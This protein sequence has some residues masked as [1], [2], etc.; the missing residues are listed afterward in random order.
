MDKEKNPQI[1]QISQIILF[2][3][4]TLCF[5]CAALCSKIFLQKRTALSLATLF[6]LLL[7]GCSGEEAPLP[8]LAPLMVLPSPT[9]TSLPATLDISTRLPESGVV[10][11]GGGGSTTAQA[12]PKP[13]VTPT[14]VNPLINISDPNPNQ[15]LTLGSEVEV[16]G[17]VQ[18]EAEQQILVSLVSSN[19]RLLTEIAVLPNEFG[20]QTAFVLPPYVSG[21]ATMRASLL[22]ADGA[23]LSSYEVPVWLTLNKAT[24]TRYLEMFRP[25]INEKAVGGFNIFFDGEVLLPVNRTITV[26]IWADDCQTRV[27]RQSFVLGASNQPVYWQGFVVVPQDLVGP[28]C[29]VASTG[30]PGTENWREASVPINVLA[31][32]ELEARGVTI[33]N[34]PPDSEVFAGQELFLYG[35]AYNVSEGTGSISILME[36]G[37]VVTQS[38]FTTDYWGYWET[39]VTLPIDIEGLAEITVSAGE[40]DTFNESTTIIRVNPAPTPTPGP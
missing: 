15:L 5:L 14:P 23:V 12:T 38:S 17:L 34:P 4:E 19:G 3:C 10:P 25:T 37:R 13:T 16:R 29:A 30:D 40:G 7:I 6:L 20:W 2:L 1:S 9:G 21:A 11:A 35:T 31:Q 27:A 39:A 8:T 26:S 22:S 18:M 36:N 33:G 24:S 32:T 28:A